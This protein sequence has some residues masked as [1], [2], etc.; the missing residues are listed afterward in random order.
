MKSIDEIAGQTVDALALL[1][2]L[3][4]SVES[5]AAV[6]EHFEIAA[7]MAGH[8]LEFPLSDESEP[9]PVYTP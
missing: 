1:Q 9:A 2:G 3:E 7:K 6:V 8:L 4:L 5:R